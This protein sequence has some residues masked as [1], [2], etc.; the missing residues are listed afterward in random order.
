MGMSS[1]I[2]DL[3]MN[4]DLRSFGRRADRT[5]YAL[6]H[7]GA[8]IKG[9]VLDV[10]CDEAVLRKLAPELDYTGVDIGGAPDV[11]LDLEKTSHLPFADKSFDCV[12]CA[13]VL[14][15]LDNL[16]TIF[17]ELI[18]VSRR[19][20]IIS[21]PNSW[22]AARVP[23]H[24]GRGSFKFYGLPPDRPADRH[25][26]FFCYSDARK[27][28]WEHA[29]RKGVT[30]VAERSTQKPKFFLIRWL[31]QLRYPAQ[32]RYLNRYCH[33]YWSVLDVCG[34]G[35]ANCPAPVDSRP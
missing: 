33:T 26:W 22:L 4:V 16:H 35:S 23:I 20:V 8:Y 31:R 13:D 19:W 25:K 5:Q 17:E 2:V 7:F 24:R 10:G 34:G 28:V 12:L 21:W 15:H 30:V 14:E 18:R 27:F 32:D 9:R 29:K 11:K 1:G 3:G 6:E